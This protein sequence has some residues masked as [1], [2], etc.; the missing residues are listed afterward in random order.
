M[1]VIITSTMV[2]VETSVFSTSMDSTWL[3]DHTTIAFG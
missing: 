3:I 1:Q 2:S